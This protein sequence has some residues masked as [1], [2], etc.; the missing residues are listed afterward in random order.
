MVVMLKRA[1]ELVK[2]TKSLG[3]AVSYLASGPALS[4][5]V[6]QINRACALFGIAWP[7]CFRN[8]AAHTRAFNTQIHTREIIT[9]IVPHI[10]A[11][12]RAPAASCTGHTAIRRH[13][14]CSVSLSGASLWNSPSQSFSVCRHYVIG[15]ST[16]TSSR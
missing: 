4:A 14:T 6:G 2:D 1:H 15:T 12:T 5:Y 13:P 8:P 16:K 9:T 7:I 10:L 11:P 3:A